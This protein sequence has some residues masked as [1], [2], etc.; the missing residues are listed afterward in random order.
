MSCASRTAAQSLRGFHPPLC[1]PPPP[2][3]PPAP[4]AGAGLALPPPDDDEDEEE[5]TVGSLTP[6]LATKSLRTAIDK[7]GMRED[8][9]VRG[10][11]AT[12]SDRS[13]KSEVVCVS[14]T[15]GR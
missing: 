9:T 5:E 11:T 13:R 10:G 6:I 15:S 2:P 1:P 8:I 3:P 12:S 4:A 14:M 7:R